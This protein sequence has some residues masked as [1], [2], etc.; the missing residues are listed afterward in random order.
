MAGVVIKTCV[1]DSKDVIFEVSP[2]FIITGRDL[3]SFMTE[4]SQNK[5]IFV[6]VCRG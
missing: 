2:T 4:F 5:S 1:Y 6:F 3:R